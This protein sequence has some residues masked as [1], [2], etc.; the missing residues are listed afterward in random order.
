MA[1]DP[2][3]EPVAHGE[4]LR[5]G[6]ARVVLLRRSKLARASPTGEGSGVEIPC[7]RT[8]EPVTNDQ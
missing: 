3:G 1:N 7:S 4:P 8:G 2:S 6:V 5:C